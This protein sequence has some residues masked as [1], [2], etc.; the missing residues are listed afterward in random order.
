M[1]AYHR[2]PGN[3]AAAA[4]LPFKRLAFRDAVSVGQARI[5]W[6]NLYTR[7]TKWSPPAGAPRVELEPW[8]KT[9][10]EKKAT[11][12]KGAVEKVESGVLL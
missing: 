6:Y 2:L 3:R 7:E 10:T 8:E 4:L 12:D 9:Y 5:Y 1:G 11:K